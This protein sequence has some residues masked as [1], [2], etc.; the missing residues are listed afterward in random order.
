VREEQA[1]GKDKKTHLLSWFILENFEVL[2]RKSDEKIFKT[3]V[4][5]KF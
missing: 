5:R 1:A 4:I 2:H 3:L